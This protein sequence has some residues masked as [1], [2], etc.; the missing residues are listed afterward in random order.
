MSHN[1][2]VNK[3]KVTGLFYQKITFQFLYFMFN[4]KWYLPFLCNCLYIMGIVGFKPSLFLVLL[5]N[6]GACQTAAVYCNHIARVL[7]FG[8]ATVNARYLISF[9]LVCIWVAH[10]RAPSSM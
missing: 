5:V 6:A 1:Y 3:I 9:S 10:E 7:F 8:V 4:S 2:S